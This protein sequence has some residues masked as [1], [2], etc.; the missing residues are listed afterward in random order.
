MYIYEMLISY[1]AIVMLIFPCN[2]SGLIILYVILG[3]GDCIISSENIMTKGWQNNIQ[4]NRFNRHAN[5]K[6][7]K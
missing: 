5:L 3:G 2:L 7:C 1:D 6:I 4:T